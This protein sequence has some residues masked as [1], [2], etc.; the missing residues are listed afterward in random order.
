MFVAVSTE[1][2]IVHDSPMPSETE[3]EDLFTRFH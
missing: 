1:G 2:D 3:A